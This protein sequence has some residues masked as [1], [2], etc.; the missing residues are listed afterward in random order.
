VGF[1]ATGAASTLM[2]SSSLSLLESGSFDVDPVEG[3]KEAEA[4]AAVGAEDAD[5]TA[6]AAAGIA[7]VCSGAAAGTSS[8]A[9]LIT[10]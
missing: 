9:N 8:S 4:G 7:A 6:D 1:G 10:R 5:T 3:D 2:L